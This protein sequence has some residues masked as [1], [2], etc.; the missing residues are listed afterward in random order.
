LRYYERHPVWDLPTRL[1]HWALVVLIALQYASG[2]FEWL[3]MRWHFWLGYATLALLLWRVLWGFAGSESALFSDF[4]RGPRAL[5]RY[6]R[7][8]L[9]PE[10]EVFAGHNPIG[11]WS[12][13]ALLASSLLQAVSGLFN[14]DDIDW[15]GPLA[16]RVLGGVADLMHEIHEV[17]RWVLLALI[18]IHVGAVIFH[19]TVMRDRLVRAMFDGEKQLLADPG[20]RFRGSLLALLLLVLSAGAVWALV[21]WGEGRLP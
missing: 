13:L 7:T 10:R 3:S 11:G 5:V 12:V 6:A 21:A 19:E 4:V 2:E 8:A 1:F 18:G 20:V 9:T 14:Q 17:N 16:H 15:I